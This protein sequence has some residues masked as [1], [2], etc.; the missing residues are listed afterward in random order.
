MALKIYLLKQLYDEYVKGIQTVYETS[1][2]GV[3]VWPRRIDEKHDVTEFKFAEIALN[4]DEWIEGFG[5]HSGSVIDHVKF[6][7]NW[8]RVLRFGVSDGGSPFEIE[9]PYGKRVCALKG[10][11]GHDIYTIGCS[12]VPQLPTLQYQYGSPAELKI[13]GTKSYG[14]TYADTQTFNDVDILESSKGQH[15]LAS[16]TVYYDESWVYGLCVEYEENGETIK[17]KG[18]GSSWERDGHKQK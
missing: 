12:V 7:T 11:Y 14:P 4:R 16:L 13:E 9:I 6:V 8:G 10:S 1:N 15:R 5:G 2:K 3:L 18:V 17:T